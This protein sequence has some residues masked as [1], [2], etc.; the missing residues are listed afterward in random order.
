MSRSTNFKR[1]LKFKIATVLFISVSV[2]A[3]AT[4]GDGG[5]KFTTL[6][7]SKSYS[8]RTISLRGTGNY[9]A[10]NLFSNSAPRY[11]TLN[12]TVTYHKGNATYTVPLKKKVILDKIK[13]TPTSN[14][15]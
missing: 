3:F 4:L 10:N 2:G 12:T 9:R 8:S 7:S 15:F 14:K 11:I 1:F 6:S 13:F 5:K